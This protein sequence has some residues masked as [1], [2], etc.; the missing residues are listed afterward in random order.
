MAESP[1]LGKRV[2]AARIRKGFTQLQLAERLG[3]SASYLNLLEH[4][5]RPLTTA[6]LLKLAQALDLDLRSLGTDGGTELASD[7]IEVL[8]DALLEDH[9]ITAREVR[10]F[11]ADHPDVARAMRRLHQGYL[12][13]RA[14]LESLA[15]R[16]VDDEDVT[17]EYAGID[18]ARLSSEQVSD[19]LERH[20]NYF[21]E[22]EAQAELTW[23]DGELDAEDLFRSLARHL[24]LAHRV[25]VV[26]RTVAQMGGA[27]RRFDPARRELQLSEALRR[28]SRTL[29]LAH[30]VGLAAC[31][32]L[33][34]R[35]TSDPQLT[36]AESRALCRVALANYFAGAV[37]MPYAEFLR[38]AEAE[39]YDIELLGHRFRVSFEQVCHRLTTMRRPGAEGVPFHMVRVDIAGNISKKFS[40]TGPRFPRYSGLCPLWNVHAAFLQPGMMRVQLQRMPNGSTFFSVARTVRKHLGGYGTAQVLYAIALGCDT[41]SARRLIYA[42]GIDLGN[43]EAAVPVGM[44]CRLCER[45]DCQARAFPSIQAPLRVDENVRG[46]SFFAPVRDEGGAA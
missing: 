32:S 40:P 1:R 23:R 35:L 28:G 7:L 44:T 37:L 39:R 4:D 15:E 8:S 20:L 24:Q 17:R 36:S 16:L 31:A 29:Q 33:L 14:S 3:I 19:Y 38:A 6:L 46:V 18:R 30:Q 42:D 10:E 2:R 11:V 22:L 43:V 25:R 21:P 41:E 9:P 5:R 12:A 34:D 26:V 27:V 13:A 45:M